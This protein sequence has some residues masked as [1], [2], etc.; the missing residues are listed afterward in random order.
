MIVHAVVLFGLNSDIKFECSLAINDN[1][2]NFNNT[3]STM[4]SNLKSS[5]N[6]VTNE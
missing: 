6:M 2:N 1:N 4:D 3:F 5:V